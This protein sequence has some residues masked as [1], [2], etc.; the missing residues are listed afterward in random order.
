LQKKKK[1]QNFKY[2]PAFA[3]QSNGMSS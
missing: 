3:V 2:C 1:K